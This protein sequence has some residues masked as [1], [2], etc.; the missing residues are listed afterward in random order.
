MV[1]NLKRSVFA[2]DLGLPTA[3]IFPSA[4]EPPPTTCA[5]ADVAAELLAH[6]PVGKEGAGVLV[7]RFW[8]AESCS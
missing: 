3:K 8:P 2:D 7:G 1:R 4:A 5:A 6:D